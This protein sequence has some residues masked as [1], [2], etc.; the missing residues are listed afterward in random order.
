MYDRLNQDLDQNLLRFPAGSKLSIAI[1]MVNN[2]NNKM[3]SMAFPLSYTH[4]E[5]KVWS[6]LLN[7]TIQCEYPINRSRTNSHKVYVNCTQLF[8]QQGWCLWYGQNG[9]TTF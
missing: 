7:L 8:L 5:N 3:V 2:N 4:W 9:H 1:S 6:E